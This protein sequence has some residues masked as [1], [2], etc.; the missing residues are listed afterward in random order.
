MKWFARGRLWSRPRL[1]A[2]LNG[3]RPS[4]GEK[5]GA[6]WRPGWRAHRIRADRFRRS[7]P[8]RTGVVA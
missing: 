3:V 7:T 4:P 5:R 2:R 1:N 8:S 6:D